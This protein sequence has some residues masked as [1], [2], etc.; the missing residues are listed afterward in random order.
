M[1]RFHIRRPTLRCFGVTATA[2]ALAVGAV[3]DLRAAN[4]GPFTDVTDDNEFC[5]SI[6][7]LYYLGVTAG[8]SPTT[9]GPSLPVTRQVLAALLARAASGASA[10]TSSR[11]AALGQFWTTTKGAAATIGLTSVGG[12]SIPVLCR[13]DGTDIWVSGPGTATVSR[14][15]A[16]DGRLLETWTGAGGA[17]DVLPALGLIFVTGR[18]TPGA[19][20]AFAPSQPAGAVVTVSTTVGGDAQG[21]AFDGEYIWTANGDGS[22]SRVTP[23]P[24]LPW[25][26][27]TINGYGKPVGILY[28]GAY[29]W[30]TDYTGGRILR[31][32]TFFIEQIVP[33]G[34]APM[35]ATFDGTNIWVPNNG[36][37]SVTVI[38]ASTGAVLTTLTGNGLN[39]PGSAAFDGQRVLVTNGSGDSVSLWRAADLTPLGSTSTGADTE[40]LGACS[41]GINFWIALDAAGAL[42]RF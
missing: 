39:N 19:L 6:L 17:Y 40:P 31:L 8:T 33:V 32:N 20:Y 10:P 14:V 25:P 23:G 42:A 30:V 21:I 29:I 41:D 2:L 38:R 9:F 13:A 36:S 5:A 37:N 27:V 11:R 35:Y 18:T 3:A 24:S 7:E 26:T 28:D 15:R 16:S 1:P 22:V 12:G 4:C 34:A